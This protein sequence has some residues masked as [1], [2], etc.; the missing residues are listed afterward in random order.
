MSDR[1]TI[2]EDL[3]ALVVEV[4]RKA[5]QLAQAASISLAHIDADAVARM[6]EAALSGGERLMIAVDVD[7][8]DGLVRLITVSPDQRVTQHAAFG[9]FAPSASRN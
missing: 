2:S 8:Q 6:T 7:T 9:M 3:Q 5:S 4:A 1:I